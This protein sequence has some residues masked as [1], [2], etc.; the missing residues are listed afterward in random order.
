MERVSSRRSGEAT[1]NILSKI[2]NRMAMRLVKRV[3][4]KQRRSEDG[5]IIIMIHMIYPKWINPA[6]DTNRHFGLIA[7]ILVVQ[8]TASIVRITHF[9]AGKMATR[10]GY[11]LS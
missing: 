11:K 5:C 1:E 7:R 9:Y 10:K 4:S 3:G 6:K 8:A 2:P